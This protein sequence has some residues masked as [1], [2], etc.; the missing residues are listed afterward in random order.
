MF[1]YIL[2]VY[3][4]HIL[5]VMRLRSENSRNYKSN[6]ELFFLIFWGKNV[7]I[8]NENVTIQMKILK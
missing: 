6:F 2:Y 4:L 1:K 7:L 8:Y 5:F 3:V